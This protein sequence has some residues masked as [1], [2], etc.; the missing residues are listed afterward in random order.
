[1]AQFDEHF[2][3]ACSDIKFLEQINESTPDRIDWQITVAYYVA[4]HLVNAHIAK[5]SLHYQSHNEIRSAINPHRSI[6][7][8]AVS[9]EAYDDF[10]LLTMLSRRAR[11]L[12]SEKDPKLAPEVAYYV[13]DKHFRR[14]LLF[15]DTILVY[16]QA[17]YGVEIPKIKLCC[18]DKRGS[19]TFS[20]FKVEKT[21]EAL[22]EPAFRS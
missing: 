15:L 21:R 22:V 20:H 8:A 17:T 13:Y 9:P 4:V 1:M 12:H 14:A 16:F 6:P 3:R 2:Q 11:Y 7:V 18:P 10:E 19:D 5:F